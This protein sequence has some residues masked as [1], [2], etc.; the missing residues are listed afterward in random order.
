MEDTACRNRSGYRAALWDPA[1]GSGRVHHDK[2]ERLTRQAQEM[3]Q[4]YG[5]GIP[6]P[7]GD[8]K[9]TRNL[10]LALSPGGMALL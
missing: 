3:A 2:V 8:E 9:L 7:S 1:A 6:L 10:K 4:K 5:F